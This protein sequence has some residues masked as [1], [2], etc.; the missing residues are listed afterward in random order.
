MFYACERFGS[1]VV[2]PHKSHFFLDHH[3]EAIEFVTGKKADSYLNLSKPRSAYSMWGA[4]DQPAWEAFFSWCHERVFAG[5]KFK[6][7][8]TAFNR[9]VVQKMKI[10]P[11]YGVKSLESSGTSCLSQTP[12][13]VFGRL[14]EVSQ[15]QKSKWH[16]KRGENSLMC[17]PAK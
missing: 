11:P 12:M 13:A 8:K 7:I 3:N 16:G 10:N 5:T 4:Y 14:M 6:C 15:L 17:P 1:G 2:K 9:R